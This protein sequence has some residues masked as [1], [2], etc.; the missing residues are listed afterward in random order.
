M[1]PPTRWRLETDARFD[2]ELRKL[3]RVT[4]QRILA[5]LVDV[6]AL[7][8]PRQ[9]GKGLTAQRSGQWRY[10][11]GD[12]RVIVLLDD[13]RLIVVALTVGHRSSVY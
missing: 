3:D 7:D 2:R 12:D 9:R 13:A 1:T 8:D 6:A 5:Y 10:R 11:I 4:Q